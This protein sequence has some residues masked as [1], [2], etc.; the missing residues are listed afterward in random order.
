MARTQLNKNGDLSE[1]SIHLAV[2]DYVRHHPYLKKYVL[3]FP[4]ESK[5]SP[6]YGKLLKDM[7]MRKGV[8]DLLIAM[9][10]MSY[11]GAWI[12]LK[13]TH[14]KP[15]KEQIVFL[16]DMKKE[17]YYTHITYGLDEALKIIQWYCFT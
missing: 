8:S 9:P 11:S 7:G 6:A 12:E 15:T 4:N 13:T 1:R 3:H 5:R 2:M 16:E 17:N 10:R 14:G